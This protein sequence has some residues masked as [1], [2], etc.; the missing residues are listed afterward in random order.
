MQAEGEGGKKGKQRRGQGQGRAGQ[1]RGR[2]DMRDSAGAED[3]GHAWAGAAEGGQAVAEG[4]ETAGTAVTVP[5]VT[6]VPDP[7]QNPPPQASGDR[8]ST[9]V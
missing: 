9:D 8:K 7:T 6:A 5:V 1:G 4:R 2:E 3:D